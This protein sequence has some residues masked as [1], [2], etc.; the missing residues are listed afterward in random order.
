MLCGALC[1]QEAELLIAVC[2]HAKYSWCD[3]LYVVAI[4]LATVGWA[5][6]QRMI[7]VY[8]STVRQQCSTATVCIFIASIMTDSTTC[9]RA[10]LYESWTPVQLVLM[11][12]CHAWQA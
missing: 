6:W 8:C 2:I 5:S 10:D 12:A 7:A 9:K 11:S 1:Q 3:L 4:L